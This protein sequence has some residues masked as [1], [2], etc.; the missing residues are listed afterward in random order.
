MKLCWKPEDNGLFTLYD[1]EQP[2]LS[3]SA[4]AKVRNASIDTLTATR[5]ACLEEKDSLTLT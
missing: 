4:K 2:L 1:A 3:A 5:T